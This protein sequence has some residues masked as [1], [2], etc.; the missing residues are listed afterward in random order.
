MDL[1]QVIA[2]L[3]IQL[4]TYLDAITEQQ[5]VEQAGVLY[6]GLIDQIVTAKKNMSEDEIE[7]EIRKSF[8]MKGFVLADIDVVKMMDNQLETGHSK[9]VPVFVTKDGVVKSSSAK[10]ISAISKEEFEKLQGKVKSIIKEISNEILQGNIAIKPYQDKG[11]TGCDFCKY[12]AICMFNPNMK[13]NDYQYIK[14]KNDQDILNE[15]MEE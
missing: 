15:L 6:L 10:A 1:N 9:V 11:K 3:Q 4:I 2:G 13:G 8:K 12:K 7:K 14:R 5:N